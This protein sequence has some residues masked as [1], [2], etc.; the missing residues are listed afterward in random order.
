MIK[1]MKITK[2]ESL[3]YH[4]LAGAVVAFCLLS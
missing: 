3:A 4:Y 2:L 1:E